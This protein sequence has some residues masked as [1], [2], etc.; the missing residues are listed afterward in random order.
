MQ[1]PQACADAL[2]QYLR[3]EVFKALSDPRRLAL[4]AEL[5]IAP[6]PLTVSDASGCCNVHFSGVSRHLSIL[7]QAGI[8]TGQ[9]SGREVSYQLNAPVLTSLLRGLADAIDDCC[10]TVGCCNPTEG[11]DR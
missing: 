11:T 2:A 7:K 9:K 10:A 4:I 3:P 5:A 1:L 6:E 8:V